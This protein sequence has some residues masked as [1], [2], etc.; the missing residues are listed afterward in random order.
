[1]WLGHARLGCTCWVGCVLTLACTSATEQTERWW[2]TDA[3]SGG[4]LRSDQTL[5]GVADLPADFRARQAIL[6]HPHRR[7]CHFADA[8]SPSLLTHLPTVEGSAAE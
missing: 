1:M 8:L 7:D 3:L 5:L 6:R 2:W 4:W